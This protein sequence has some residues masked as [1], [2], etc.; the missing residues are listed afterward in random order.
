MTFIWSIKANGPFAT[1]Y[2]LKLEISTNNLPS[3]V[4]HVIY[5]KRVDKADQPEKFH[6]V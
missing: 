1:V 2:K 6:L 3:Y 4:N 5:I